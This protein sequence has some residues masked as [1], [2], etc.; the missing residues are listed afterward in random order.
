M[1]LGPEASPEVINNLRNTLGLDDPWYVRL[2][3]ISRSCCKATWAARSSRTRR[4]SEI[5]AGRL[6][7]TIEL[8][9]V[10]LLLASLIGITLGVLAAIRQG[11]LIDTRP[12][13]LAQLGV[14][15]PVYWLGLLLML[16]LR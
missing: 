13:L 7:A 2:G 6:G 9:V 4:C 12:M 10:A 11:S 8:A 5:I 15:M 1:L 16:P 14:S 3:A